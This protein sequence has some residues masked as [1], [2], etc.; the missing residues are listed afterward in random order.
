[1]GSL[2]REPGKSIPCINAVRMAS[3]FFGMGQFKSEEIQKTTEGFLLEQ[4]LEGPYFQP[5]TPAR[6]ITVDTYDNT[7]SERKK[8]EVCLLTQSVLITETPNSFR[9]RIRAQGTADVP[10]AVEINFREGGELT[11]ATQLK[12][13]SYLLESGSATYR[14]GKDA[15]KISSTKA[16][17]HRYVEV[18][19]AEHKLQGPSLFITGTTPMDQVVEISW[20]SQ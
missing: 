9:I 13:D 19:G 2:D 8:S 18:R 7:R 15:V 12:P 10:V 3:A 16:P 4:K 20:E 17:P 11:G 14:K 5:F 6:K 1:M